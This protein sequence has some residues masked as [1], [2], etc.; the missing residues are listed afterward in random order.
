MPPVITCKD[1]VEGLGSFRSSTGWTSRGRQTGHESGREVDLHPRWFRHGCCARPPE[2]PDR[3]THE[4]A[5]SH[6][7][8]PAGRTLGVPGRP[9]KRRQGPRCC[10]RERRPGT[11]AVTGLG[12]SL[13]SPSARWPASW[14]RNSAGRSCRAG[15]CQQLLSTATASCACPAPIS[16]PA[17]ACRA[18]IQPWRVGS[19]SSSTSPRACSRAASASPCRTRSALAASGAGRKLVGGRELW[20]SFGFGDDPWGQRERHR[21]MPGP[22]GS[23]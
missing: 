20:T 8:C 1:L 4:H 15:E 2:C 16:A 6:G 23:V 21:P 22:G 14:S 7:A 13:C 3:G 12:F 5:A 10:S 9:H 18:M 11:A 17:S 19:S